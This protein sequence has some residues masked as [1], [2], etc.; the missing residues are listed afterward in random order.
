MSEQTFTSVWDAIDS[1]PQEAENMKLRSSLMM[2]LEQHIRA[3]ACGQ[4][5]TASPPTWARCDSRLYR[6]GQSKADYSKGL[7][8]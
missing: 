5:D 4:I 8:R 3:Q 7:E 6:L 2:A 1:T